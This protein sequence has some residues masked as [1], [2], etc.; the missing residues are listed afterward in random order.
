MGVEGG[1]ALIGL[2]A[3]YL[4]IKLAR[5]VALALLLCVLAIFLLKHYGLVADDYSSWRRE[6]DEVSQR[7]QRTSVWNQVV[8]FVE[9]SSKWLQRGFLAGL[10]VGLI[11]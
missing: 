4:C 5:I 6:Y 8:D 3:G 10:W 1:A 2:L 7:M 9:A 11:F